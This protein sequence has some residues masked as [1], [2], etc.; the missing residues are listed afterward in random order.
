MRHTVGTCFADMT[1]PG[2]DARGYAVP[3]AGLAMN[4]G[5]KN[6]AGTH[7]GCMPGVP[8][9]AGPR[10]VALLAPACQPLALVQPLDGFIPFLC[11]PLSISTGRVTG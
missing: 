11:V 6:S 2:E 10:S 7:A 3:D 8:K 1:I 5:W 9:T 4:V